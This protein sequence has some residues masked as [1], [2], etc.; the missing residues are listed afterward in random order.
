M[1][2][3]D[4]DNKIFA[5]GFSCGLDQAY[6]RMC[7]NYDEELKKYMNVIEWETEKMFEMY[8][9]VKIIAPEVFD[10]TLNV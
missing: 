3:M 6:E 2:N 7:G 1:Y 10:K 9:E 5:F 4:R 8:E